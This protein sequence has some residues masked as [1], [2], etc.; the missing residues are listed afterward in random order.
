MWLGRDGVGVDLL[1][2]G[3]RSP[4]A[5]LE[6]EKV[7]FSYLCLSG[8]Q[9][10]PLH[11][12]LLRG[13]NLQNRGAQE[14]HHLDLT[15]AALPPCPPCYTPRQSENG[16]SGS[17]LSP[18]RAVLTHHREVFQCC[19]VVHSH[20]NAERAEDL[21]GCSMATPGLV[22]FPPQGLSQRRPP[23]PKATSTSQENTAAPYTFKPPHGP[24]AE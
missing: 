13:H 5:P 17:L 14:G 23:A 16:K 6:P 2:G 4:W 18:R 8:S 10:C 9:P 22:G 15:A 12:P 20:L 19:R 7:R 24:G 11:L 3:T 1:S 21:K